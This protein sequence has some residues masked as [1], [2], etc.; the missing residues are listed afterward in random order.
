MGLSAGTS[1]SSLRAAAQQ[2]L[3]QL[4]QQAGP[5]TY[6]QQVEI[7][8]TLN[9]AASVDQAFA[10]F[11]PNVAGV[12]IDALGSA[13][14][15]DKASDVILRGL[16]GIFQQMGAALISYGLV[17][18][19][20][21]PALLNPFTS[22]IAAIAAGTALVALG[23]A[24]GGI[25]S[26][27]GSTASHALTQRDSR[28][29]ELQRIIVDPNSEARRRVSTSMSREAASHDFGT[30]VNIEVIGVTSSQG[31]RYISDARILGKRRGLD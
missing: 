29:L 27:K 1:G 6:T 8:F 24:L 17:M 25:A 26:G 15:G 31:Q 7:D 10:K 3:D 21:L 13:F 2:T 12:L 18:S 9:A 19:G 28:P 4:A 30:P 22:G 11:L 14:A 16:G 5:L 20:L 23:G